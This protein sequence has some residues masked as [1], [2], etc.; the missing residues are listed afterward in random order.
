MVQEKYGI[1]SL[2]LYIEGIDG[3][4]KSTKDIQASIAEYF[5]TVV[6]K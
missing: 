2:Y 5:D 1:P 3:L 6:N 4:Y